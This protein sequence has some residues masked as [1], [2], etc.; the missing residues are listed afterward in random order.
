MKVFDAVL[1]TAYGIHDYLADGHTLN[2][3]Y[4]DQDVCLD[5]KVKPWSDGQRLAAYIAKVNSIYIQETNSCF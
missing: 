2:V 4:Y 3:S 1:I 5:G